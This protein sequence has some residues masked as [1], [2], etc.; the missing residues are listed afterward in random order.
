M[1]CRSLA[2]CWLARS[3]RWCCLW[4]TWPNQVTA[5]FRWGTAIASPRKIFFIEVKIGKNFGRIFWSILR[6]HVIVCRL[7]GSPD[8]QRV[9]K[10]VLSVQLRCEQRDM[11]GWCV[12]QKKNFY[13]LSGRFFDQA[14]AFSNFSW[15]TSSIGIV[16]LQ[17]KILNWTENIDSYFFCIP[18]AY[19]KLLLFKKSFFCFELLKFRNCYFVSFFYFQKLVSKSVREIL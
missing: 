12:D 15:W 8:A 17:K 9:E 19:L 10:G 4:R 16:S 6:W 18:F 2:C 11:R 5:W 1:D 14:Y 13:F 3:L 7:A